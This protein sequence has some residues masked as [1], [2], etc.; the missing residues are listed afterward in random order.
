LLDSAPLFA[1]RE[2][3]DDIMTADGFHLQGAGHLVL[4]EA[5]AAAI[6]E[7]HSAG[8]RP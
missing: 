8:S 2:H 1:G 4:G 7:G 5:V 3:E 6:A